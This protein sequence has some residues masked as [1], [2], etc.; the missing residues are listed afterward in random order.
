MRTFVAIKLPSEVTELLRT[1]QASLNRGLKGT[2][3]VRPESIHL[4]LKFLGEIDDAK[5]RDVAAGLEKAAEGFR[6]FSLEVGGVGAFPNARAPKVVWA[7]IKECAEL[8]KL[9]K[10]VDERL[11]IIGF[12]AETRPFT[13]HLTLCRIKSAE[14]GRA[15]GRLIAGLG[16]QAKA[17]FTVNSFVFMKSV[18]KPQG[19]VHTDIKEFALKG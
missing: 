8:T 19:A 17:S 4:T 12:E 16:E 6:P 15:L 18:L 14:D 9:Q 7:G 10:S 1:I 13:P 2:S 5:V 3:W 11:S